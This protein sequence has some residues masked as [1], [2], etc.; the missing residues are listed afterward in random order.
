MRDTT[1]ATL[2]FAS[3]ALG[4]VV[5]TR[6]PPP[7]RPAEPFFT[8]RGSLALAHDR[9]T[10]WYLG[11]EVPSVSGAEPVGRLGVRPG[12]HGG[13]WSPRAV[14]R[15]PRPRRGQRSHGLATL[16]MIHA[17]E[18]AATGTAVHLVPAVGGEST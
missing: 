13:S 10:R 5:T 11:W 2:R 4:V 12:R 14:A 18:R 15:P 3:G 9:L 1:V 7:G 16:R 8:G 6:A 17:I